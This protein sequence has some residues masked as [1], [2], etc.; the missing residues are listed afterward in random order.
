MCAGTW[1]CSHLV[2][3]CGTGYPVRRPVLLS[4][5]GGMW[6]ARNSLAHTIIWKLAG[7]LKTCAGN[8]KSSL[9]ENS[10]KNA[11]LLIRQSYK[12]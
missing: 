6:M 4:L 7:W 9:Q 2:P 12:G 11:R 5:L 3:Q 1:H 10:T 8:G